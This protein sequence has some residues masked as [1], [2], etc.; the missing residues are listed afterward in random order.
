MKS[1]DSPGVLSQRLCRLAGAGLASLAVA[2]G[3]V[4]AASPAVAKANGVS[5]GEVV[6][7]KQRPPVIVVKVSYSCDPGAR[8]TLRGRVT[9]PRTHGGGK[10]ATATGR[11]G[12]GLICDAATHT[13]RLTTHPGPGSHFTKGS[14]VKVFVESVGTDGRTL[15]D[16]EK[17]VRL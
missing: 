14:T 13:T 7:H 1:S 2:A 16:A 5:V 11:V 3:A 9:G 6:F 17:D 10:P 4:A 15:A 12:N 8:I